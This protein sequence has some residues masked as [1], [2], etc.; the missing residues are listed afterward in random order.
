[1][2]PAVIA[3]ITELL[4]EDGIAVPPLTDSTPL[5]ETGLD[6]LGLAVVVARLE[7][8]LGYDPFSLMAQAVYPRTVGELVS[9][10]DSH[11]PAG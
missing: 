2:R 7:T 4:H 3:T 6:S 1:M 8:Q 10:Y 9:I 11:T 5:L